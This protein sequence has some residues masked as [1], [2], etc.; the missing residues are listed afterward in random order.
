[1]PVTPG[2]ASAVFTY[3]TYGPAIAAV[4]RPSAAGSL[5]VASFAVNWTPNAT[6]DGIARTITRCTSRESSPPKVST[7]RKLSTTSYGIR[8]SSH[9]AERESIPPRPLQLGRDFHEERLQHPAPCFRS[10]SRRRRQPWNATDAGGF[11]VTLGHRPR[12]SNVA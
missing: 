8:L 4:A 2:V 10:A 1:M 5:N 9:L 3:S 6:P 12:L 7:V 11:A